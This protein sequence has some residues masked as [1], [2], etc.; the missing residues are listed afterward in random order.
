VNSEKKWHIIYLDLD[1]NIYRF[2]LMPTSVL[3]LLKTPSRFKY[4]GIIK[5]AD[6]D[7]PI[8]YP[9]FN[10]H[11]VR[12]DKLNDLIELPKKQIENPKAKELIINSSFELHVSE[13]DPKRSPRK[14]VKA[15]KTRHKIRSSVFERDGNKCLKCGETNALTMDHV[16]PESKGG[17]FTLQNLQ[18]L[19]VWCNEEKADK[20]IDYRLTEGHKCPSV[21]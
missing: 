17:K 1:K 3:S 10:T 21:N 20:T 2:V 9:I 8:K 11:N 14:F 13:I 18:T 12:I 7:F 6:S 19:C 4:L 16:V 5:L 15:I